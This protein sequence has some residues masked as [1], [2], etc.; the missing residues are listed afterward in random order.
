MRTS[1]STSGGSGWR[2]VMAT[3][4]WTTYYTVFAILFVLGPVALI[5]GIVLVIMGWDVRL[6]SW[7]TCHACR[8]PGG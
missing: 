3:A 4:L 1:G 6:P 7:A 2:V 8:P 5:A